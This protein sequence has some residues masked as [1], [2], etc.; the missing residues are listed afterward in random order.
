VADRF[1]ADAPLHRALGAPLADWPR[2]LQSMI[3]SPVRAA[4]E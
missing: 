4:G 2:D 1:P 3:A